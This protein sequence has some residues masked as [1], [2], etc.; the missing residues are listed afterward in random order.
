MAFVLAMATIKNLA[1]LAGFTT[2]CAGMGKLCKRGK[3]CAILWQ[4]F[5]F[6]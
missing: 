1:K 5:I 3:Y 4:L 2:W 6:I